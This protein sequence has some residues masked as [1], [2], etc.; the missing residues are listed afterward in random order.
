MTRV[1]HAL[2][3]PLI[4]YA[5]FDIMGYIKCSLNEYKIEK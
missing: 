1:L 5:V 4:S 2:T 3:K